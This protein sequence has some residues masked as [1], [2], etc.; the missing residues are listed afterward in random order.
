MFSIQEELHLM[1]ICRLVTLQFS[2]LGYSC[3]RCHEQLFF[4]P[5]PSLPIHNG[6]AKIQMVVAVLSTQR[7]RFNLRPICMGFEED[8]LALGYVLS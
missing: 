6:H 3:L 5:F 4:L 1:K 7:Y 2:T 8:K